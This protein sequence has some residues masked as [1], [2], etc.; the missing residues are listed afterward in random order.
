MQWSL[1]QI[2]CWTRYHCK[3]YGNVRPGQNV[4]HKTCASFLSTTAV[5]KDFWLRQIFVELS[6]RCSQNPTY[7]RL[8][9][10]VCVILTK[11][12]MYRHFLQTRRSQIAWNFFV[13]PNGRGFGQGYKRAKEN[14]LH[15]FSGGCVVWFLQYAGIIFLNSFNWL[16]C[17]TKTHRVYCRV[18]S[19]FVHII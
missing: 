11:I 3:R 16:A 17:V 13:R 12:K 6:S 8:H 14:H 4:G 18:R 19:L 1:H 9:V 2:L 5:P 15:F 10:E 7:V